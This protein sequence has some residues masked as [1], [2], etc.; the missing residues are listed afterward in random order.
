MDNV[1]L[2]MFER[3]SLWW[4]FDGRYY[5]KDF[6]EGVKN[7]IKWF[8]VIWKD[9]DWHVNFIYEIIKV[10]LKNQSEYIGGHDRHISAKRDAELMRLTSRLI[11]RCQDEYYNM[12]Y[13]DYHNSNYNWLDIEDN[14]ELKELDI[15]LVDEH[16]DDFFKKYPIQYKKVMSGEINRFNKL[17]EEKDNQLIAMEIAHENQDRCRKLVF[18]I[19]ERNIDC[20]WD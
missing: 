13:M 18:K 20:W 15:E 10:K 6:I 4:K 17:I 8:P 12:E 16:F 19:M 14:P 5:H 11:Q 2:N 9:R 7:L 1:K 3:I